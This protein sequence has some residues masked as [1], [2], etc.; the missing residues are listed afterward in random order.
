MKVTVIATVY[1]EERSI[2]RLLDSLLA[3]THAADEIVIAD[4][5]STD[6]TVEIARGYAHSGM[7]LRVID[8]AGANISQGRNIAIAAAAHDIIASTDAGV[9]LDPHWLAELTAPLVGHDAD[10]VSGFFTA[11]AQGIFETAMGATVLPQVGD[12]RADS[13]LPS[14]R[15][16]AFTRHAW[17]AAGGYPE[18]LDYCEDVVFDLSLRRAGCRFAFAPLA[19]AYFRPRSNLKSFVVQYYRYARGDG[20]ADLWRKRHTI[21]YAAYIAAPLVAVLALRFSVLWLLLAAAALAYCRRPYQRLWPSLAAFSLADRLRA[22][23]LVPI[24]RFTGDLAKMLGYPVG[25][26]WRFRH[27]KG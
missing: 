7:A 8:A 20:K 15:S 23:V 21:R 14:S 16:V 12:V 2:A 25:V 17:H 19:L 1:N 26:F 11:D 4:G 10:V 27:H 18:W 6:R 9:R 5:G 3:Q 13:F 24:I 22:L